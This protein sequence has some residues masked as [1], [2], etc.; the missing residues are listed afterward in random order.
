M[1]KIFL[2]ILLGLLLLSGIE[3]SAQDLRFKTVLDNPNS[4]IVDMKQDN[5]GF[6]WLI[7]TA[8]GLQKFDG[9]KAQ[10]FLNDPSNAN[11]IAP[12]Q[13]SSLIIDADNNLW[14]GTYGS[15]LDRLDPSTNTFTHFRNNPKDAFSLSNDTVNA[16]L[17]DHSGNLWIGTNQGLDLLDKNTGRFTHFSNNN[18]DPEGSSNPQVFKIYEDR[19]GILWI[20][21]RSSAKDHISPS[22]LNLFDPTT[23][24]ITPYFWDSRKANN[25]IPG[26]FITDIYEDSK[27]KFWIVTDAGLYA[28]D[29]NTGKCTQYY[30]DPFN[31][32]TLS[33]TPASK[34]VVSDIMFVTEDSSRALWVGMGQYGLNRYDP[35]TKTS[36][37]F[38]LLYDFLDVSASNKRDTATGLNITLAIKGLSSKDGLFWVMGIGGIAQLNYKK[39]TFLFNN[40]SKAALALYLEANGKILWIGTDKGLLR[41]DLATQNE[42]LLIFNPK[43]NKTR[44]KYIHSIAADEAGNL[45]LGTGTGLLK[46]DPVTEKYVQ[47][48]KDLKNPGSI[49]GNNVFYTF[50]DH[51][52]NLW[53]ASDS[54]VSRMDLAT[55][56]FTNYS[57]GQIAGNYKGFEV[58]RIAEDPE[59]NIWLTANWGLYKLDIKTGKFR[60]YL[61]DDLRS[62]CVD[63]KGKVWAGGWQGLYA[64]NKTKDKFELFANEDSA[65]NISAVLDI[66]EDDQKNL[67]VSTT[68]SIIRINENRTKIKKYTKDNGVQLTQSLWS[69]S[70]FKGTDGRLFL[71]NYFGYYSFRPDQLSDNHIS[72]PL[73][74]T[75]FKLGDKLI[76]SE[77]S[78]FLSLPIW[79]TEEIKLR[80]DE[81]VFSFDFFSADYISS[82][83]KKYSYI[84][85]NYDNIWHN[86]GGEHQ[87][88]FFNIP[89]GNYIFKVKAISSDGGSV[90]KSIR[91]I[92]SPPW[93]ETWWFRILSVITLVMVIYSLIRERSRKLKEENR[94]LEQNVTERTVQLKK[95]LEELKSTQAQLIQSEKLA[96]LGELTAGIAHEIQNPLNFVNNFSEVSVELANELQEA[97]RQRGIESNTEEGELVSDLIQN[98]EKIYYHG[99]RASSIVKGMLEHSR[100]STG[101]KELT[102]INALA[103]EYLRLAYHG[104]RAKDNTFNS[105]FKTDFDPNLPKIAVIPQ[106]MGRVLLNL[107]NNA[108]YATKGV[109]NP[110][111]EVKTKRAENGVVISVKDNGSGMS[112]VT[113]AKIF[114][115]FFTTKPTGE[116]T[117]LGLSLAYD[118]VTKGHGGT[119]EVESEES[120]GTTFIIKLPIS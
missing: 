23:K 109:K 56:R 76:N 29:R 39:T 100:T 2:H 70:S 7:N 118:I 12:G 27:N 42:K 51:N 119:I 46:F 59:H 84:L 75:S 64:F 110:L 117:G 93:W 11:S 67:W 81:N 115:P 40:I 72:P 63:A 87:A 41:K 74:I 61:D 99:K 43:E 66:I 18:H 16:I 45:W 96:S 25:G 91:I 37:H 114:Q 107:I 105:D 71:G 94:R 92:I 79:Q 82:T 14:L 21:G 32:S 8:R 55:G 77:N 28:M 89:P 49:S 108:F 57:V 52:K 102:D 36:M 26:T 78:G 54:G 80:H 101:E 20:C 69:F 112:E 86:I 103:D 31:S 10:T 97:L 44:G 48:K 3:L 65:V 111:V 19:K 73:N 9:V 50:F 62:I 68:T 4:F 104:L 17:E 24:K 106:D 85:E 33:R 47:Y 60:K 58:N 15:G 6:F 35:V 13:V 5:L 88:S 83:D 34:D 22:A 113:K 53:A 98:Q 116:G 30:P 95:S 1:K 90:E 120:F 38:G